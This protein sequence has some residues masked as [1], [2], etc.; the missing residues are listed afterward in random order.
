MRTGVRL[1]PRGPGGRGCGRRGPASGAHGAFIPAKDLAA[2]KNFFF[3]VRR[4]ARFGAGLVWVV[5]GPVWLG[6]H[7]Q[8][9]PS[10][11]GVTR[12]PWY[13]CYLIPLHVYFGPIL[14]PRAMTMPRAMRG[15]ERAHDPRHL[16]TRP[17]LT[18]SIAGTLMAPYR[19]RCVCLQGR[20]GA[21]AAK[22][23]VGDENSFNV[24][25]SLQRREPYKR[26][27]IAHPCAKNWQ[28]QGCRG[29]GGPGC[30][31][32]KQAGGWPHPCVSDRLQPPPTATQLPP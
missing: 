24:G 25:F 29:G 1:F 32:L 4:N 13:L 28:E 5:R 11:P 26:G 17:N 10:P 19:T 7:P 6:F 14:C 23:P 2:R 8:Q 31:D 3:A 22:V 15:A 21:G 18:L 12:P 30:R 20:L 9:P 27:P 16:Q